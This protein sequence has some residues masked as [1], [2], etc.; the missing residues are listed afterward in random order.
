MFIKRTSGKEI[1]LTIKKNFAD[2]WSTIIKLKVQDKL[3]IAPE[4][5][6][7]LFC[8]KA[9]GSLYSHGHWY[10]VCFEHPNSNSKNSQVPLWR[11][12]FCGLL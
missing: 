8:T 11:K 5:Q 7:L 3:G 12:L 6:N 9:R 10:C 4:Y 1:R 2:D